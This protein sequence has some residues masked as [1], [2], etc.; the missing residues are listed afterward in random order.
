VPQGVVEGDDA[1]RAQQPQ[2]LGEVVGVLVLVAVAEHEVVVAVGEPGDHVE[3]GAGDEP[4]ALGREARLDEAL[5]G[6]ALVLG[7]G[8]HRG[9][10]ALRTHPAQ[11]PQPGDAGSGADLDDCACFEHRCQEAEGRTGSRPDRHDADLLGPCAGAGQDLVLGHEL[12]GVGPARGLHWRDDG[13]LLTCVALSNRTLPSARGRSAQA[14]RRRSGLLSREQTGR[15]HTF[16][17]R[18]QPLGKLLAN[19]QPCLR[20]LP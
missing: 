13:D 8:V 1:T 4:E 19:A 12:L 16:N 6:M 11:Q 18:G 2:R 15:C 7:L 9:E 20:E 14:R 10:D 17:D 5:L 3:C